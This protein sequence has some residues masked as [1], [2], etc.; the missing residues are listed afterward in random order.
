MPFSSRRRTASSTTRAA[1][2]TSRSC[3]GRRGHERLRGGLAEARLHLLTMHIQPHF[4]FNTLN[5]IPDLVHEDPDTADA[6][7]TGLSD[8]LRRALDLG[9]AQQIP[10][11][12]ELDLL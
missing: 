5:R 3:R 10:F 6:M 2:S 9:A 8:L 11:S 12:A 7:I 1:A 4:L